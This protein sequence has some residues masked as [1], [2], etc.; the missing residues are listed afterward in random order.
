M[1]DRCFLAALHNEHEDFLL[2]GGQ[3]GEGTP[4][5]IGV[6]E[7]LV[8]LS[9]H[10][11]GLVHHLAQFFPI[12]GFEQETDRAE[13]ERLDDFV[14]VTFTANEN[15]GC[16]ATQSIQLGMQLQPI[17]AKHAHVQQDHGGRYV[18]RLFKKCS[19]IVKTV[20]RVPEQDQHVA[21]KK[22]HVGV[23]VHQKN[24]SK[25]FFH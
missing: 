25:V 10:V 17:Q 18:H 12:E 19:G 11:Q 3:R 15:D 14:L 20:A 6:D 7:L 1:V 23:V 24:M 13:S 5:G 2:T 21:Q 4:Q 16:F 8:A 9:V 22:A